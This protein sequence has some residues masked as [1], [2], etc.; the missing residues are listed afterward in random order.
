M[1]KHR[2]LELAG[3]DNSS[4]LNERFAVTPGP[5]TQ[6][7]NLF[8]NYA[9]FAVTQAHF[10]HLQTLSFAEHT[11]IGSFY[12]TLEEKTDAIAEQFIGVGGI[13]SV[14][15]VPDMKNYCKEEVIQLVKN[16]GDAASNTISA[17]SEVGTLTVTLEEIEALAAS[18]LFKLRYP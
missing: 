17:V 3:I 8:I 16:V 10:W 9:L 15:A 2:L 14:T 1:N 5:E 6:T 18:T 12:S 13:V 11:A 4:A 7:I